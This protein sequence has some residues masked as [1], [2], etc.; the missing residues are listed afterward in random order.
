[1]QKREK[2][3]GN[4]YLVKYIHLLN[5]FPNLSVLSIFPATAF[6]FQEACFSSMIAGKNGKCG[7]EETGNKFALLLTDKSLN[8]ATHLSK[9]TLCIRLIQPPVFSWRLP[10]PLL[11]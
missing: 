10:H 9:Q 8:T 6:E 3:R 11:K 2:I 5:P 7:N 4:Y 1:M